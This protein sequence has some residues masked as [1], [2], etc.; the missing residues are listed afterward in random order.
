MN[1]MQALRTQFNDR[2][3]IRE[4]RPGIVQLILPLYHEDGDMVDIFL[5]ELPSRRGKIR[6]CDYGMALMRLSYSFDLNTPR[7]EEIF[8]RILSEGGISEENGNLFIEVELDRL[9]PA[10]L[11]FAQTVAKV[12]S[13]RLYRR[14][15]IQSLFFENLQEIIE[16]RLGKFHPKKSYFPL[17]DHEEYE[18]DYCFN[19]RPKP[20]YLFG[21]NG[22]AP[23]RLATMSC[24]KFLL[25]KLSFRSLIVLESLDVLPRKDQ[26][27]L[28][29]VADKEFPSLGDFK[30]NGER[31]LE[32]EIA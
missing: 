23:A 26:A 29:S 18:V 7:K 10:I 24:Q 21:V 27:R 3:A 19:G 8:H 9:Y 13:M 20:I 2:F 11:Q 17:P 16:T 30:E 15:V 5:E 12:A 32:R 28:M 22:V 31:Y 4:K 1:Y 25:E 6:I 14:E